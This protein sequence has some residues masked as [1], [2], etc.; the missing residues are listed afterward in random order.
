MRVT[1]GK[2]VTSRGDIT[3]S[4][5]VGTGEKNRVDEGGCG[6]RRGQAGDV[7]HVK[8]DATWL[9]PH[10]VAHREQGD[11]SSLGIADV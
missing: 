7:I 3:T 2:I 5:A 9:C 8:L 11:A 10:L 6:A 1:L 4:S